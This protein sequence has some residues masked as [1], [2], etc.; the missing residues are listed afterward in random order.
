[1]CKNRLIIA[2]AGSGK[3]TYLVEKAKVIKN[4]NVL[5]TTYTESN[6][7]EIR[8]KFNFRI[9]KN[10][11]IQTWFSFLLQHG[12]RPYQNVLNKELD[13]V[14]IGFYLASKRSG[15]HFYNN[16][17]GHP[18]YW[19][20]EQNFNNHY[21]TDDYKIY[22]DKVS[23]FIIKSNKRTKGL[24]VN[25]ISRIYP[26]IFIDEV[27][28]LA[29]YDLEILKLLFNSKSK[30]L[31]VGDPRQVTYLTHNP[32]KYSK[33]REGRLRKFIEDECNKKREKVIIDVS[34]LIES[35]RNN[36]EICSFSSLL[37][38]NF[39]KSVPCDCEKCRSKQPKHHGIFLV[40]PNDIN[41]YLFRFKATQLRWD[42]NV[43]LNEKY[44]AYNFGKSKG[45]T[46]DNVLIYPTEDMKNWISDNDFPLK[47]GTRAK[48]YVA[49]TRAKHSVGIVYDYLNEIQSLDG[50]KLWNK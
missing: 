44:P 35:H 30:V 18:V 20:E 22:S 27:Q 6:E 45:M 17:E 25:R 13:R 7:K 34:S 1:M 37:Y 9:P 19:S 8:K 40:K 24:I 23:K 15:F 50:I 12:V 41:D 16:T 10:I 38:E 36:A 31:L 26:Y 5:I 48:F 42:V 21:F 29:G 47:H 3:T 43:N 32:N 14:N 49:I 46:F 33:Y 28:D 4:E 11:R 2:A 39:E